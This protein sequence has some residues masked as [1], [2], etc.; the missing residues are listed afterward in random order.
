MNC[1][2]ID[3]PDGAHYLPNTLE[4]HA[5]WA[6]TEFYKAHDYT[7]EACKGKIVGLVPEACYP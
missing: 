3:D 7:T 2:P 6:V 5:K 1:Q 4:D